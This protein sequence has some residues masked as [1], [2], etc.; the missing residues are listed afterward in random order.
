MS[1]QQ[2]EKKKHIKE[3]EEKLVICNQLKQTLK[4]IDNNKNG[5]IHDSNDTLN[6]ILKLQ[7]G[8]DTL[9]EDTYP[10]PNIYLDDGKHNNTELNKSMRLVRTSNAIIHEIIELQRLCNFKWWKIPK[11][12][13]IKQI[14]EEFI[15]IIFFVMSLSNKL[16]IN[17][18]QLLEL[19]I[20]KN[21]INVD[22]TIDIIQKELQDVKNAE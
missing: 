2:L 5:I 15:D 7:K 1:D 19:Y 10:F 22:R 17:H 13:D 8:L 4:N 11:Q 16:N 3:L 9:I 14:S 18:K 20:E 21:N 6:I 12:L